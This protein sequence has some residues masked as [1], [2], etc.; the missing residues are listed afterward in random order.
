MDAAYISECFDHLADH[1]LHEY[2]DGIMPMPLY[3]QLFWHAT[4]NLVLYG[5]ANVLAML[6]QS[7]VAMPDGNW[8]SREL[9]TARVVDMAIRNQHFRIA[10]LLVKHGAA[11]SPL[12]SVQITH[13]L[14]GHPERYSLPDHWRAVSRDTWMFIKNP[15]ASERAPAPFY[16]G[17]ERTAS[18]RVL[19]SWPPPNLPEWPPEC[20]MTRVVHAYW[21]AVKYERRQEAIERVG[22]NW[23]TVRK[24]ARARSVAMFWWGVLQVRTCAAGGAG[25]AADREAYRVE[26]EC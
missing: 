3:Q 25:R 23:A 24:W 19:E 8:S 5:R 18:R 4:Q 10:R 16:A 7:Q 6:L 26:Y 2:P 13:V 12:L 21:H 11:I 22:R 1:Y 14:G 17:Y 9:S 15:P 20:K